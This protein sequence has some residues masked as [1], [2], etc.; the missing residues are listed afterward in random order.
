MGFP[1]IQQEFLI[2]TDYPGQQLFVEINGIDFTQCAAQSGK[3]FGDG[4]TTDPNTGRLSGQLVIVDTLGL[5]ILTKPGTVF[6]DFVIRQPVN[7]TTTI[8]K[9]SGVRVFQEDNG[10]VDRR[11]LA[12]RI[13][14]NIIGPNDS[15]RTPVVV[16][17]NTTIGIKDTGLTNTSATTTNTNNDN[18]TSTSINP[19]AQT[20]IIDGSNYRNGIFCTSVELYFYS[21][22]TTN[23]GDIRIE[24]REV[25]EGLPSNRVVDGTSVF[26]GP[27]SI[28]VSTSAPYT[29][30]KFKFSYPVYLFPGKEYALC[31]KAPDE[32]Y[33]L[34]MSRIGEY[35][36]IDS[37]NTLSSKQPNVG[38]LY[39]MTNT[40]SQIEETGTSILFKINKAIFETGTKTFVKQNSSVSPAKFL[41]QAAAVQV[42]SKNFGSDTNI[43]A[44][45]LSK[46]IAGTE[47]SESLPIG[48]IKIL[49]TYRLINNTGDAK[50][51]FTIENKDKNISPALNMSSLT[52]T[53][54]K[55][56]IDSINDQSTV[57]ETEKFYLNGIGKSKYISKVITLN[58]DFDSTGLE[59]KLNVNRKNN[60]DID[61]FCRVKSN[62]DNAIDSKIEN[63]N[64][65]YMPIY[66][67]A[68]SKSFSG[69]NYSV[70]SP[71]KVS[72]GLDD[73]IFIPETYRILETDSAN[74][75][76][77]SNVGGVVT[78][79]NTFN[80]FQVK[81]VM[82]GDNENGRVPK[83]KNL[84]ATAVI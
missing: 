27:S 26:L 45:L 59:V 18:V 6:I 22:S 61:V 71:T 55:Y 12:A 47:F 21:K 75:L 40:G 72:V 79:F 36:S 52:F 34:Y 29:S 68:N 80:Q 42:N 78:S 84:I 24:L 60:T 2:S 44:E 23:G 70:V 82:Y 38:K 57:R 7:D 58:P 83:V 49:P 54:A 20:F 50:V 56:E 4:L 14:M 3:N 41:Y 73:T 16:D 74:L 66:S 51:K 8:T 81:I 10:N 28:N 33:G 43:T 37:T 53:T 65:V 67:S 39:K 13:P 17:N 62:F 9:N 15:S 46:D 32:N 11:I 35:T 25:L 5:D 63:L 30:T 69:T 31:I 1:A 19:L 48:S 76:Y 77:S 64:W